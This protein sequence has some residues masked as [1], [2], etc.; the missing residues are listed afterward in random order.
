M[1]RSSLIS[2]ETVNRHVPTVGTD[3]HGTTADTFLN[4]E[5]PGKRAPFPE[6]YYDLRGSQ[7][8]FHK[9]GYGT[10]T[11]EY[12]R[13]PTIKRYVVLEQLKLVAYVH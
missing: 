2:E 11:T 10:K 4:L 5:N 8:F 6:S 9:A 1:R 12:H 7:A 3:F 13:V